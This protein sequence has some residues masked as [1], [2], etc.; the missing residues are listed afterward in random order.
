MYAA[1]IEAIYTVLIEA[2]YAVLIEVTYAVL[3]EVTYA[4]LIE[5][6]Y[7]VLIEATLYYIRILCI[8]DIR[9][10]FLFAHVNFEEFTLTD[11]IHIKHLREND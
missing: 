2:T 7:A 3:I 8:A 5:V 10:W 9:F 4:V 11:H 1:L 6:T